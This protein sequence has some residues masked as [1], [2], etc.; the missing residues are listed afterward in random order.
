M[1]LSGDAEGWWRGEALGAGTPSWAEEL[2][3]TVWRGQTYVLSRGG[4]PV[5]FVT[6]GSADRTVWQP[7]DYPDFGFHVEALVVDRRCVD[8]GV[9]EAALAWVEDQACG[10]TK[11]WLRLELQ[12][13]N[14]RMREWL[15]AQGFSV[16]RELDRDG[17]SSV[18]MQRPTRVSPTDGP[19]GPASKRDRSLIAWLRRLLVG[20]FACLVTL[21]GLWGLPSLPED[22]ASARAYDGA[23]ACVSGADDTMC[24]RDVWVTVAW[25]YHDVWGRG[26]DRTELSFPA[27]HGLTA[28]DDG[29]AADGDVTTVEI[30]HSPTVQAGQRVRV[31]VWRHDAVLV[32]LPDGER[33]PTEDDPWTRAWFGF[34]LGA[35]ALLVAL[36]VVVV[37]LAQTPLARPVARS[38]MGQRAFAGLLLV[39]CLLAVAMLFGFLA[40]LFSLAGLWWGVAIVG[41]ILASCLVALVTPGRGRHAKGV[42][43]RWSPFRRGARE[44][45]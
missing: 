42:R 18:L 39:T 6:V 27:V 43:R 5:G 22:F 4:Q 30:D 37:L 1:E 11:H 25:V 14:A 29:G 24:Y 12:A 41:A 35:L 31:R 19:P 9:A 40:P 13:D 8:A 3:R 34:G 36:W 45:A 15:A 44:R 33:Q 10:R 38:P 7:A 16:V 21:A 17:V 2:R 32:V 23:R 28:D 20:I 26:P